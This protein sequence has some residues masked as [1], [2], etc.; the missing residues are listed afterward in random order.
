M[1][2]ATVRDVMTREIFALAP[3][4]NLSTAARLFAERHFSGAPVV[5][6]DGKVLGVVSQTD[7]VDPDR[8]KTDRIGK[9][10]VYYIDNRKVEPLLGDDAVSPDG[11]VA[12]V[13]SPYVLHISPHATIGEAIRRM[14]SLDVHRL[15]VV[16]NDR[17][18]GILTSMDILRALA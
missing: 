7:L 3:D 4:T 6:A 5:S 17:L 9:S 8:E 13:M 18:V 12:D 16:E 1:K 14:V 2:P 11:V 15:L 10:L